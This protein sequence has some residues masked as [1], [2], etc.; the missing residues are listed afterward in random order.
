MRASNRWLRRLRD[1]LAQFLAVRDSRSGVIRG[2]IWVGERRAIAGAPGSLLVCHD[3]PVADGVV[4][5]NG[6]PGSGK[7]TLAGRVASTLQVPLVSQDALKEAMAAAAPGV[8]SGAVGVAAAEVMWDLA[9]ATPGCV[10][11]ESWWFKPRDLG[12]VTAG[13]AR[14]GQPSTVEV[15]CD[16]PAELALARY[17]S[18]RRSAVYE[19]DRKLKES[20]PRWLAEAE[21]LR[22]GQNAGSGDERTRVRQPPRRH[23]G[24]ERLAC[25][26]MTMVAPRSKKAPNGRHLS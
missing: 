26:P 15:W 5:V 25:V 18:R 9:A 1:Q 7:T 23:Q 4:L 22:V 2:K 17:R 3:P 10:V 24:D 11:L 20:W 8:P 19:D 16:V 6:L 13:L 14:C 12:F 21:P